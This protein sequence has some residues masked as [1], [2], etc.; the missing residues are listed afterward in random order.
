[1]NIRLCVSKRNKRISSI[2]DKEA[3]GADIA[4][5][6]SVYSEDVNIFDVIDVQC[7]IAVFGSVSAVVDTRNTGVIIAAAT[8]DKKAGIINAYIEN[9]SLKIAL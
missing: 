3:N 6:K 2:E 4:D 1:M 9:N 5:F 8:A 7:T